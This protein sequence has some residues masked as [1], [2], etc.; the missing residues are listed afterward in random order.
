MNKIKFTLLTICCLVL[1]VT[2]FTVANVQSYK[3]GSGVD[4]VYAV[5]TPGLSNAPTLKGQTSLVNNILLV[6]LAGEEGHTSL[7]NIDTIMDNMEGV[8][9][10]NADSIKNYYK[11]I[12]S[13]VLD[14]S[15][16]IF[17][18]T[19]SGNTNLFVYN[20]T[21]TRQQCAPYDAIN[22]P[23]GFK[24][25]DRNTIETTLIR[26]AL[27]ELDSYANNI[28]S[29]SE[30]DKNN[31]GLVDSLT[32][33]VLNEGSYYQY[34]NTNE[35]LLWPHK[36]S[37]QSGQ[38]PTLG[39]KV[40]SE[41]MLMTSDRLFSYNNLDVPGSTI[42]HEMGHQLGFPD[43]YEIESGTA[44]NVGYWDVMANDR[45]QYMTSYSRLKA[46]W[47]DSTQF[48]KITREGTYTLKP[49]SYD[50]SRILND[51][52][53][54]KPVV[55][56]YIQDPLYPNQLIC[57]EFRSKTT[58]EFDKNVPNSGLLIYRVDKD[59]ASN[60]FFF[61]GNYYKDNSPAS[62]YVFRASHIP[63]AF[64]FSSATVSNFGVASEDYETVTSGNVITFQ[65]YNKTYALDAQQTIT[66]KNSGI[67]VSNVHINA[68]NTISFDVAGPSIEYNPIITASDFNDVKLFNK[69]VSV[70]GK[71]QN[72]TIR[73]NDFSELTSLDLSGLDITDLTGLDLINL[74][75]LT[76]LNLSRNKITDGLNLLSTLTSLDTLVMMECDLA[77]ISFVQNI[78]ARYVN[79]ANNLITDFSPLTN[80]GRLVSAL[81]VFNNF[82]A[83][84]PNNG[85]ILMAVENRSTKYLIGIQNISNLNYLGSK[86]VLFS[87]AN[88][89]AN[90]SFA[91]QRDQQ[92]IINSL[93]VGVVELITGRYTVSLSIP[94]GVFNQE[95]TYSKS[96]A[97]R[98]INV[99]LIEDYVEIMQGDE[100]IEDTATSLIG[101]TG[102]QLSLEIKTR[103]GLDGELL[104]GCRVDTTVPGIY[105]IFFYISSVNSEDSLELQKTVKVYANQEIKNDITGIPDTNLYKALLTAVGKNP[106][107]LGVND[108]GK[109]F[110]QDFYFYDE[111]N[112]NAEPITSLNLRNSNIA[113]LQGINQLN[114]SKVTKIILNN[115]QIEDISPLYNM[116]HLTELHLA[117]NKI[118]Q[119][120]GI[121]RL[122]KLTK[123]DLSYNSIRNIL[124]LK[125]LTEPY[126]IYNSNGVQN[127]VNVN[128]MFNL[129]DM[130]SSNNK[131]I[132]S[133][134]NLPQGGY[135]TPNEIFI[136]LVQ[137][138]TDGDIYTEYSKFTY[139]QTKANE[140]TDGY[141]AV[142]YRYIVRNN[143]VS[144]KWDTTERV[145]TN[146]GKYTIGVDTIKK[147][148]EISYDSRF[149]KVC[150]VYK[151]SLKELQ[152]ADPSKPL[153][154]QLDD[155]SAV[156]TT[157]TILLPVET[158]VVFSTIRGMTLTE[159]VMHIEVEKVTNTYGKQF[160]NHIEGNYVI[161][162]VIT[163]RN[164][165]TFND[166]D[167][168]MLSR[169]IRVLGN[170]EVILN[171]NASNTD[172]ASGVIDEALFNA[173]AEISG[174]TINQG[175]DQFNQPYLYLY[176]Y[177]TYNLTSL[178]LSN[179][180][181]TYLN[182][183]RDFK[184]HKLTVLRLKN[185]NIKSIAYL[186]TS[187]QK[188]NTFQKLSVL[189]LSFNQIED[190]SYV[191]NIE[192]KMKNTDGS[193]GTLY[194]NLM[195]NKIDL[196]AVTNRIVMDPTKYNLRDDTAEKEVLVGIQGLDTE[197]EVVTFGDQLSKAGFYYYG[198]NLKNA[199]LTTKAKNEV[200]DESSANYSLNQY[201]YFDEAGI[202]D[203][204]FSSYLNVSNIIV[205]SVDFTATIRHGKVYL[206]KP[207]VIVD[208]SATNTEEERQVFIDDHGLVFEGMDASEF[209]I[210]TQ[211]PNFALDKLLTYEQITNVVFGNNDN[212]R[213]TFNRSV[214]V[215]DREA[216]V[217]SFTGE[218]LIIIQK[219]NPTGLNSGYGIGVDVFVSDNYDQNV[220]IDVSIKDSNDE[221]FEF[222]DVNRPETY[223]VTFSAIDLSGNDA[224]TVSRVIKVNYRQY[225]VV[226]FEQPEAK[227][228]TGTVE[229][230][231]QIIVADGEEV[232]VNPNPIFYWFVDGEYVGSSEPSDSGNEYFINTSFVH[233]AK[234]AGEHTVTL[235]INNKT[236]DLAEENSQY[237]EKTY[238]I[239]LD[240][241]VVNSIILWGCVGLAVVIAIVVG[242]FMWKRHR[243]NKYQD[244]DNKT[245]RT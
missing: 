45:L 172:N 57:F 137:G 134:T 40:V 7:S 204:R 185:N 56:Y 167:R 236:G 90:A 220:Q 115:N 228:L 147:L 12:S 81:M 119:I 227:L 29:D 128:V 225:S 64:A 161:N 243:K 180:G 187:R 55:C 230:K 78:N 241:E 176:Q 121:E 130:K 16:T 91:I 179:K 207:E 170:N 77:D 41:Y 160:E 50:E 102:N 14:V 112:A 52:V 212:Y 24:A 61:A 126:E 184:F 233:E 1:G 39:N 10:T 106:E 190:A 92:D 140:Y 196:S 235:R 95:T 151:L 9:N 239:L 5:E 150:Y 3:G 60:E 138:L 245:Y 34:I 53:Q 99:Q 224:E 114:L 94:K 108:S 42:A 54:T 37:C 237:Y 82:D 205:A 149:D 65:E 198:D 144:A 86:K 164:M 28:P 197:Q 116:I 105:Y 70:I 35:N 80:M 68:D 11:A 133:T 136:V 209:E 215:A 182:G 33:I 194:I 155:P 226:M 181:I 63:D 168:T 19:K 31:D 165:Y 74:S 23:L 104:D 213:Y 69:L 221:A 44:H 238:F 111:Q 58:S 208:Y 219:G 2:T 84:L 178:D 193:Y 47:I 22:N 153:L 216:P 145:L 21:L 71:N 132:L 79:F 206:N 173:I 123:L 8:L 146:S 171:R 232:Y 159:A 240:N 141:G 46:N 93:G 191:K 214:S 192:S 97:F 103:F 43:L 157:E 183:L 210:N 148:Y 72:D 175:T 110:V 177:D 242:F 96:I 26:T 120:E 222:V 4:N 88:F 15:N 186:D 122:N 38:S 36:W 76:Y 32:V 158:D 188:E 217:I 229:F 154:L 62:I 30:L 109:L 199:N 166:C 75:S 48:V 156:L 234:D 152:S 189:D 89:D 125:T 18:Q 73:M 244:Y 200:V 87:G 6:T 202:H 83:T 27:N 124:A 127:L 231:A 142:S 218:P 66:Y 25:I 201:Y 101:F 135:L 67:V 51:Q 143:N 117:G 162:Y 98:V 195:V 163:T 174:A 129:L 223:T 13:G 113:T 107:L 59:R 203:V 49:V 211:I 139:H 17:T 100:Y 131:W 118:T 85:A 169:S 20:S